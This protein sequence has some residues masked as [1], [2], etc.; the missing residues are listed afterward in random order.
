MA[1]TAARSAL[2]AS[3]ALHAT[4]LTLSFGRGPRAMA[5]K[6]TFTDF[7]AG[8]TFEVPELIGDL[9]WEAPA[10]EALESSSEINA[11]GVDTSR[12]TRTAPDPPTANPTTTAD[13]TRAANPTATALRAKAKG[14]RA[15]AEARGA[16]SANAGPT[17]AG[18]EGSASSG[19][20]GGEGAAAGVRDLVRSFVRAIPIVA[21]SDPVWATLPLGAAGS[22]EVTLGLNGE[23]KPFA[24]EPLESATP[25]H[26]RRLVHKTLSVMS[27][28]R[29]GVPSS[30]V[31]AAE[32][33]L[34]IAVAVTQQEAPA[35]RDVA[36]GGAFGLRFE[37][38]DAH[39]VSRAF[40]TLASGRRVEVSV[41]QLSLH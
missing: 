15:R 32:Q 13:P 19:V 10:S 25:A 20:F 26:L 12:S 29:F 38:A 31:P 11:E 21:S 41:R 2:L 35:D 24:A 40:F 4:A 22:A 39:H 1:D 37:P 16:A 9:A 23:G 33:K 27:S 14:A 36:S 7:W 18:S 5:E 3:L 30:D 28:G 8:N 17:S 6:A 34:R